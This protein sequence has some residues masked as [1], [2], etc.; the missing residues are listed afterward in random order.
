MA[1]PQLN[2]F[3][4]PFGV[5]FARTLAEGAIARIGDD[6]LA[7]AD[8]LVLVPTRR[9][10]RNLREAFAEVR[11]GA[12]LGPNIRALGDIGEDDI[13]FDAAADDLTLPPAI[14]P[15]RR[16]LLLATLVQR[17]AQ[18][19]GS[20]LPMAQAV[21][22][23]GELARLLDEVTTHDVKLSDLGKLAP[24]ALAQHW[25]EVVTF[26]DIIAHK[27][28]KVLEEEGTIEPAQHRDM[29]LRG[30]AA[31]LLAL[32]PKSPVIAAG[33]TGSIPATAELLK[34]VAALPNGAVV[35]PGLD[36][37][38][39][40][41][42]WD[43]LDSAH[44]QY[45]LRELLSRMGAERADVAPWP[46]LPADIP[47][48]TARV[49]FL[50]EAL[51]PP[52][53]TDAWRDLLAR[54]GDA[55]KPAFEGLLLVEAATTREEALVIA[56]AL[57]E[58]LETEKQTAALVT[59]DR[60]LARRVAAELTRW[61][62]AIDDSAGTPLSRT[63]VG[64]FLALLARAA[65]EQFTPVPLL[66][67]LKHPLACGK[68]LPV[69]FRRRARQLDKVAMRG[70]RPE[71]GLAGVA[72]RL[73]ES[74]ARKKKDWPDLLEWFDDVSSRLAPF[75][76]AIAKTDVPLAE[77]ASAHAAA[78]ESLAGG[79]AKLWRNEDGKSAAS[80]IAEL[81][82]QGGGIVLS[83]GR[84]YGELFRD[85]AELRPVRPPYGRHPRLAILG[86]Q[87][88]RLLH[89]DLVILGG[90]NE[91][92]W[93]A[94][95]AND[96]FLSRPMRAALGLEAPERRIGLAAHDFLSLGAAPA[97]LMTRALKQDGAPTVPSRWLQ[98]ITQLAAGLK[99][100]TSLRASKLLD[101]ARALD[102][103]PPVDRVRRPAYVPRA[104][105]PG[106]TITDVE[107]WLRD[108][109]AVYAKHI[110]GLKVLRPLEEEPGP[111]ERGIAVHAALEAFHTEF[112]SDLPDDAETHLMRHGDA[113]FRDV[114]ATSEVLALW[115]PRFARAVRWFV[116]AERERRA[117]A[118]RSHA[119]V[120]G[121]MEMPR[122]DGAFE[123]RGRADRIDVLPDRSATII[124]YKTGR[125]PTHS[126]IEKLVTPQLP[127]EAAMLLAGAFEGVS[128]DKMCQLI[129][130][131]LGGREPPGETVVAKVD[132]NAIAHEAMARLRR[133]IAQFD[134]GYPYRSRVMTF[135]EREIGDY[136]QLARVREWAIVEDDPFGGTA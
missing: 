66:A 95:A 68:D 131:R 125:A 19:R 18:A 120:K 76:E 14:S 8:M 82:E 65:A 48:R 27:W 9:A 117:A 47:V 78:A 111:R 90:L 29:L 73:G 98:R 38:M 24:D 4:I 62:I 32:P 35:L 69:E 104:H 85:L 124:D 110:L 115:R 100:E 58:A 116:G 26:L 128:A 132:A 97:V 13:V 36:T 83:E 23:A 53:T 22:H 67:L 84:E 54:D 31:R 103:A 75:V 86:T 105:L 87:E 40:R 70:L 113:A 127:L 61:D 10:A 20:S 64:T 37:T 11:G 33:S 121:R 34:I 56:V 123:L 21:S 51:R 94:N 114:G 39:D 50:G 74:L 63:P 109:Y 3:T 16:R 1:A 88:A 77:L 55:L 71:A 60:G 91:G 96:P 136:D 130:V 42:S 12:A 28:P 2:L 135:N 80:L 46:Q 108:P 126:Q 6:P 72:T 129:H 133:R 134:A 93:P 99:A 57:R 43:A 89:F 59:P 5:P 17:W 41:E 102:A 119:E 106:L 112:P 101:H 7:L 92:T 118:A 81:I 30:I 122:D 44:A 15:L 45:G 49:T 52:P 107:T 25:N 79:A